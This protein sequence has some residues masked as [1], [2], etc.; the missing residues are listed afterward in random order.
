[1]VFFSSPRIPNTINTM[2]T[3][4][5]PNCPL[6]KLKVTGYP[7]TNSEF[8]PENRPKLRQKETHLKILKQ[9]QC[10]RCTLLVSGSVISYRFAIPTYSYVVSRSPSKNQSLFIGGI[11]KIGSFPPNM[12]HPWEISKGSTWP[13]K[14]LP[15]LFFQT[16]DSLI[17]VGDG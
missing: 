3:W 6:R 7:E 13:W 5:T 14:W 16:P 17:A 4:G 15:H 8:T 2:G 9:P 1:M 11:P 12:G 10:F